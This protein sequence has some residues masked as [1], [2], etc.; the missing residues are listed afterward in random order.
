MLDFDVEV[1]FYYLTLTLTEVT[2]GSF[3]VDIPAEGNREHL[4]DAPWDLFCIP[5]EDNLQI[6]S[7]GTATFNAVTVNREL[8]ISIAQ[9]M[10]AGLTGWLLDL[11]IVPYSCMTGFIRT[12]DVLDIKAQ[13]A[14]RYTMVRS[15]TNQNVLPMIWATASSGTKMIALSTPKTVDNVKM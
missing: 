12:N 11:Q 10:A 6:E 4:K 15:N 7:T 3:T 2:S 8:A 14:N 13:N 1:K 9:G 5:F